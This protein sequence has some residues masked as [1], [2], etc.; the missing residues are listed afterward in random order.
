M[1]GQNGRR[2]GHEV[3]RGLGWEGDKAASAATVVGMTAI[4][5]GVAPVPPVTF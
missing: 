5:V 1:S 4:T 2:T 3:M